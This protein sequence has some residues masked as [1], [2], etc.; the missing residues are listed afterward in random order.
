ML[1]A[2]QSQ[3]AAT[4]IVSTMLDTCERLIREGSDQKALWEATRDT[5]VEKFGF[6]T[7]AAANTTRLMIAAVAKRLGC[8]A[9]YSDADLVTIHQIA[10]AN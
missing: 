2:A 3:F 8:P 5:L 7:L 9:P 10:K 4:V 6:S 1:T